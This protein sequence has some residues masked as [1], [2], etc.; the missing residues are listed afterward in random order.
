MKQVLRGLILAAVLLGLCL[1]AG[2]H[3][4]QAQ[5]TF[6]CAD[7]TQIPEIECEALVALYNS[8]NGP[9]WIDHTNWLETN[10]PNDWLGV[11]AW[12]GNVTILSLTENGLSGPLPVELVN[13][14]SLTELTLDGNQL[15]GSIPVEL[16]NLSSL[17]ILLLEANEL[18][19]AIPPELG[20]LTSFARPLSRL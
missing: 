2:V 11:G 4:V 13:L 6:S 18:T 19:G 3:P 7:V 10:T 20:G 15:T 9:N 1:P 17:E 12:S 16:A 8:T 14:S 5:T